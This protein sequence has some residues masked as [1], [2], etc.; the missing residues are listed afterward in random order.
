MSYSKIYFKLHKTHYKKQVKL[1]VS[2]HIVDCDYHGH[3]YKN[4]DRSL[5]LGPI[6]NLVW[7]RQGLH[8]FLELI[9]TKYQSERNYSVKFKNKNPFDIRRRKDK[10]DNY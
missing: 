5:S 4:T 2:I 10:N 3:P 6:Q 8:H 1:Y 9:R 7:S